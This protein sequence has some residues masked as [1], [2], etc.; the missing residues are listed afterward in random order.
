MELCSLDHLHVS[1]ARAG[2]H[3]HAAV[4]KLLFALL[5]QHDVMTWVLPPPVSESIRFARRY[6]RRNAEEKQSKWCISGLTKNMQ[7]SSNC[8]DAESSKRPWRSHPAH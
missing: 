6:N 8:F 5:A 1:Y 2:Q 4:D 7:R 3:L